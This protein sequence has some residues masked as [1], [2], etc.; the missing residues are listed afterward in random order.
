[1]QAGFQSRRADE[2]IDSRSYIGYHEL[3]STQNG[4]KMTSQ[5]YLQL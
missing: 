3:N 1:M 4:K 5:Q 2:G